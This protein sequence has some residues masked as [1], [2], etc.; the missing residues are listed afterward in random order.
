VLYIAIQTIDN[1]NLAHSRHN[2]DVDVGENEEW[3]P[4]SLDGPIEL[5]ENIVSFQFSS[6]PMIRFWSFSLKFKLLALIIQ[7][8]KYNLFSIVLFH[9]TLCP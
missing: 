3:K 1:T 6:L 8:S 7:Y 5:A 2:E 4:D 9:V